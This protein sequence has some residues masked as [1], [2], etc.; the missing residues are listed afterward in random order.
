M[1]S[2]KQYD[3]RRTESIGNTLIGILY[4]SPIRRHRLSLSIEPRMTRRGDSRLMVWASKLWSDEAFKRFGAEN[5]VALCARAVRTKQRQRRPPESQRSPPSLSHNCHAFVCLSRFECH[6]CKKTN[7]T[8]TPVLLFCPTVHR[9]RRFITYFVRFA[10][11]LCRTSKKQMNILRV[12]NY[13]MA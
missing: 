11:R 8:S 12:R 5:R 7:L 1:V 10:K 9:W 3:V 2:G 4:T 13:V 6:P